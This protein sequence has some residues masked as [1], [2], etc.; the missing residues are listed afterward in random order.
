MYVAKFVYLKRCKGELFKESFFS[1]NF[2]TVQTE[3]IIREDILGQFSM[4]VWTVCKIVK[5][6]QWNDVNP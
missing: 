3:S 4:T 2:F 5:L 1:F 6:I